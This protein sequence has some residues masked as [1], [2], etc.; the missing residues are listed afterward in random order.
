MSDQS[1]DPTKEAEALLSSLPL[2][3]KPGPQL[4]PD[5][6][7]MNHGSG[8]EAA[9]ISIQPTLTETGAEIYNKY[10]LTLGFFGMGEINTP[11]RDA[12]FMAEM[13]TAM[14]ARNHVKLPRTIDYVQNTHLFNGEAITTAGHLPDFSEEFF[15]NFSAPLDV[16]GNGNQEL[17]DFLRSVS[18][19]PTSDSKQS[20]RN[21]LRQ[22]D[23][24]CAS[25]ATLPSLYH[26]TNPPPHR[27]PPYPRALPSPY[28]RTL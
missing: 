18:N 14:K 17:A 23:L 4:Q 28:P 25:W 1:K 8:V 7:S 20:P 3:P 11:R 24:G 16:R 19:E 26:P 12:Q 15:P 22:A 6:Y 13:N 2:A 10:R 21:T 27:P 5:L 9:D